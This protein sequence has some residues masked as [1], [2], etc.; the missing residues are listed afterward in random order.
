MATQGQPKFDVDPQFQPV[1]QQIQISSYDDLNKVLSG[2]GQLAAEAIQKPLLNYAK[3]KGKIEGAKEDFKP[4]R[5][6][7]TG[8]GAAENNAAIQSHTALISTDITNK[9]NETYTKWSTPK[10]PANPNGGLDQDSFRNYSNEMAVWSKTYLGNMYPIFRG[11]ATNKLA[12]LGADGGNK[13][14]KA[15]GKITQNEEA[16]NILTNGKKTADTTKNLAFDGKVGQA[17]GLYDQQDSSMRQGLATG[18]IHPMQYANMMN[19][20]LANIHKYTWLGRAHR[21]IPLGDIDK[22]HDSVNKS[23]MP[24]LTKYNLN[25]QGDAMNSNFITQTSAAH[26]GVQN[27]MRDNTLKQ[28][29]TGSGYDPEL[30]T[31]I[32]NL[33]PTAGALYHKLSGMMQDTSKLNENLKWTNIK[34]SR[35]ALS[36]IKLDPKDPD[37]YYKQQ[38]LLSSQHGNENRIQQLIKSPADFTANAPSV[39]EAE[40]NVEFSDGYNNLS[41]EAQQQLK[42][43]AGTKQQIALERSLG[44]AQSQLGILDKSDRQQLASSLSDLSTPA[45]I[46]NAQGTIDNIVNSYGTNSNIA[47]ADMHKLKI[48]PDMLD[49]ANLDKIPESAVQLPTIYKAIA[50]PYAALKAGIIAHLDKPSDYTDEAKRILQPMINTLPINDPSTLGRTQQMINFVAKAAMADVL[51][52]TDTYTEA[53][54][55]MGQAIYLNRYSGISGDVR[56]PANVSFDQAGRSMQGLAGQI[57]KGKVE[58]NDLGRL[59]GNKAQDADI[60]KDD[61]ITIKNGHWKTYSDD[62][63]VYWVDA[64]GQPV[65]L[66]DTKQNYELIWPNMEI[67]GSSENL[68]F[69]QGIK[70]APSTFSRIFKEGLL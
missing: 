14:I 43:Q 54:K 3:Q 21:S 49:I 38:V 15:V 12:T 33:S 70:E 57:Q 66:K 36:V 46:Q 64:N 30:A 52:S 26:V 25:K 32:A 29:K 10:S 24:E 41:P 48:N 31:K 22:F 13:L 61:A 69:Q 2:A 20:M 23:K 58:F 37:F 28:L 51:S 55:K 1:S 59:P 6:N 8:L 7:F 34:V 44:L 17:I 18:S 9:V 4:S 63:G 62:R 56:V 35:E 42:K 47:L 39:L 68:R 40:R 53:V 65:T 5:F 19:P 27:E 67:P 11:D 60:R 45:A 50:T 16:A